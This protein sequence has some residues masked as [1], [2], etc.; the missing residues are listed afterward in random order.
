MPRARRPRRRA[1][2]TASSLLNGTIFA[3][4]IA[5]SPSP[6]FPF[7]WGFQYTHFFYALEARAPFRVVA[8]SGEF[9]LEAAQQPGDC[10]SIQFVSG[11]SLAQEA[12]AAAAGVDGPIRAD[13]SGT[14]LLSYGVNDCEAKV[15]RIVLARILD[16][17]EPLSDTESCLTSPG[18]RPRS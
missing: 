18:M 7:Q 6:T 11:I 2:G 16:M 9:C 1:R 12:P 3:S 5:Q 15:G 17:L 10:E 8:T 13:G 4:L 14:L